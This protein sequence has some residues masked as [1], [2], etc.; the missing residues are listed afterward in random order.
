[1]DFKLWDLL[2]PSKLMAGRL[3]LKSDWCGARQA[4]ARIGLRALVKLLM[5]TANSGTNRNKAN[6]LAVRDILSTFMP[7]QCTKQKGID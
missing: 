7:K 5:S 3:K 2:L 1:M 4:R 6:A